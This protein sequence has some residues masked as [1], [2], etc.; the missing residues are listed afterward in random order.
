MRSGDQ[1]AVVPAA[2]SLR[3][4]LFAIT[5]AGAGA[6]FLT[7]AEGRLIG[8]LTDGDVRRALLKDALALEHP[9]ENFMTRNPLAIL[10]NPLAA[11]ALG[12]LEDFPRPIGEA[13]VV[14]AMGRPIGLIM[15]KDLLRTGIV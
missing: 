2:T 1:M 5:K 3:D 10:G 6:A 12:L 7:D 8:L 15:L 9:A 14:D 13:P 11:E 4:V